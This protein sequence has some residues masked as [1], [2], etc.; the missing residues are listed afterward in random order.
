[1]DLLTPIAA[2]GV[3]YVTFQQLIQKLKSIPSGLHIDRALIMQVLDPNQFPLIK[4]IEGEKI[5]LNPSIEGPARSVNDEQKDREADQIKKTAAKQ[6]LK[7]AT[8]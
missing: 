7:S 3:E 5:F 2:S 6:A 4:S 8:Q 1:L